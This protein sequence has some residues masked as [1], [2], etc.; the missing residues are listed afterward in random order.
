MEEEGITTESYINPRLHDRWSLL[1]LGVSF[2]GDVIQV[3]ADYFA[4]AAMMAAQHSTQKQ[5]DRKFKE[6]TSGHT[7]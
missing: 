6:I 7:R 4:S 2:M 5:Y 1:T 3:T